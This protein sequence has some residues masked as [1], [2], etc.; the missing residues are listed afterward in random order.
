MF[1]STPDLPARSSANYQNCG[2]V[3][4]AVSRPITAISI[5]A[6]S[7]GVN[8]KN[9]FSQQSSHFTNRARVDTLTAVNQVSGYA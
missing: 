4:L 2:P 5:L 9:T 7:F 3:V 6:N 8:I 1:A